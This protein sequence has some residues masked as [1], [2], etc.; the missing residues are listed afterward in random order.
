[1]TTTPR[2]TCS[3]CSFESSYVSLDL[4]A[5]LNSNKETPFHIF[6]D[7]ILPEFQCH[8]SK[9]KQLLPPIELNGSRDNSTS[10]I[11]MDND[12]HAT[13]KEIQKDLKYIN[14][15]CHKL[16]DSADCVN[17][18]IQRL[19]LQGLDD[20]FKERTEAPENSP[21]INKLKRIQIVVSELKNQICSFPQ[22]SQDSLHS[23]S[24]HHSSFSMSNDYIN[25]DSSTTNKIKKFYND[26]DGPPK[27]SCLLCF[28]VFPEDAIIKKK[29]L[30]HWWVGEGFII[31]SQNSDGKTAEETGNEYFKDF[32]KNDIIEPVHEGLRQNSENRKMDRPTRAAIIKLAEENNFASFDQRGNPTADFSSSKRVCLVK[33]EEGSSLHNLTYIYHY[34]PREEIETL[35]NVNEP[36]LSF[37]VD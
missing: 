16:K 24:L 27:K 8:L 31:D 25:P 22:L 2:H 26:L 23:A 4:L 29:V 9:I 3:I 1:M 15:A 28:S 37:R 18:E 12:Q 35:F 11:D 10:G 14:K 7:V 33:T 36:Y 30:I 13:F 5:Y 19:I 32:I 34:L 6:N 17:E 21:R 20:A